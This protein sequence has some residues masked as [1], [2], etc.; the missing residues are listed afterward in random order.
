MVAG[1]RQAEAQLLLRQAVLV[2]D[3]KLL[4]GL[5]KRVLQDLGTLGKNVTKR[6][7]TY[8]VHTEVG[9]GVP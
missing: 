6:D 9:R 1:C 5:P 3:V 4:E 7:F 2:P 8:Y